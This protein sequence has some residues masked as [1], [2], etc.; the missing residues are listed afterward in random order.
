MSGMKCSQCGG[1]GRIELLTSSRPC[2]ACKPD[3]SGL[4]EAE[5]EEWLKLHPVVTRSTFD[6]YYF[7][8]APSL[9]AAI[10]RQWADFIDAE[11]ARHADDNFFNLGPPPPAYRSSPSRAGR[12]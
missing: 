1:K 2:L 5:L 12:P 11:F 6:W 10:A 9:A 8:P 7:T 4:T 3:A